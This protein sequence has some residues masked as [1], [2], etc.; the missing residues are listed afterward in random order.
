MREAMRSGWKGSRAS[1]FSPELGEDD[2]VEA[3]VVVEA[4]GDGDGVL[5]G[6]GVDDEEYFVRPD[7]LFDGFELVHE[8]GVDVEPAGGVDEDDVVGVGLGVLD[9]LFGDDDRLFLVAEGE[10]GD[11]ELFAQHFEL[12]DRRRAV[13]VGRDEQGSLV[14]LFE[15]EGEL[16]GGG[17][18][19][20]ALEADEHYDGGRLGR[21]G[22]PALGAAHEVRQFV[23][24]DFD[25]L[26][27]GGEAFE[28]VVADGPFL[29]FG[30]EVFDDFEV[31][32]GLQEGH[33]H[34]AHSVV[35][36]CFGQFAP[37]PEFFE[38]LLEFIGQAFE[39]HEG[40][41]FSGRSVCGEV[42]WP[43]WSRAGC[44][45]RP[46]GLRGWRAPGR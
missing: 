42:P 11:F 24:D 12:L 46:A 30:D 35:D 36:V 40:P 14:L 22:D 13:Y 28:H 41:P 26:L 37:A 31:D 18:L 2:A 32:V 7:G 21:D 43:A 1:S 9:C 27:G 8:L 45:F 33:A 19:A 17:G 16:A 20:G 6:H 15:Q 25:D 34:F 44:G 5:A 3:E 4:F 38:C 29:D 23:V 39:Y 10:H